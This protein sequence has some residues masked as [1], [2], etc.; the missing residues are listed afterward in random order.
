MAL[1]GTAGKK[2]VSKI[3]KLL[4]MTSSTKEILVSPDRENIMY[5]VEM[6][7]KGQEMEKLMWLVN[8]A[9]EV[10]HSKNYNFL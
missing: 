2:L 10:L 9:K 1:T 5:H 4:C 8:L 7:K 3:K 6:V